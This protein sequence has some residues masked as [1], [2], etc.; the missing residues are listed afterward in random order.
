MEDLDSFNY[1][2][3]VLA[4]ENEKAVIE[5]CQRHKLLAIE[6]VCLCG[7]TMNLVKRKNIDGIVWRCQRMTCKK[8][9]TIRKGSFFEKSKLTLIQI[10]DMI[11][12]WARDNATYTNLTTECNISS[13]ATKS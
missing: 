13:T 7:Q 5:F 11:Y 9:V 10:M 8:E 6:K 12:L 3:L 2:S 1:R 4:T